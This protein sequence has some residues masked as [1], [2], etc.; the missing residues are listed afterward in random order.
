MNYR[1]TWLQLFLSLISFYIWSADSSEALERT[2]LGYL[3]TSLALS[4]IGV[5]VAQLFRLQHTPSP[6]TIFGFYVLG[7]PLAC[8]C[9]GSAIYSL[10]LG[11]YRSWRHQ[12]AM[13]RGKAIAGGLEVFLLGVGVLAVSPILSWPYLCNDL[14]VSQICL[15]FF[16]LMIGVDISKEY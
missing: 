3:R 13:V 4:M 8:I 5:T 11:A 12:H 9:Q 2:F 14:H 10:L 16:V 1:N 6:N 15:L 7:K